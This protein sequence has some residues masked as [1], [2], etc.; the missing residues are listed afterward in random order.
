[1]KNKPIMLIIAG[2]LL[3]GVGAIMQLRGGA[4]QADATLVARCQAEMKT[5]SA[6]ADMIARCTDTA[7]ATAMT[8]TDADAAA[9]S[10]SAANNNEIGSNALAMFLIGLG[11]VMTMAGGLLYRKLSLNR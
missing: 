11:F 10:I 2:L 8:A 3:L 9:R 5:R 1:M 7:F 4:P 6:D